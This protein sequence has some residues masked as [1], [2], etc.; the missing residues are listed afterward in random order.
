MVKIT[1]KKIIYGDVIKNGW[2]RNNVSKMA[3]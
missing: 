1:I 2:Q 3:E